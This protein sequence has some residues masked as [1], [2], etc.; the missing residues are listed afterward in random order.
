MYTY[1]STCMVSHVFSL[2]SVSLFYSGLFACLLVCLFFKEREKEG[3]SWMGRE[4]EKILEE[5]REGKL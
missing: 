5:M 1:A 2:F 4:R 3:G